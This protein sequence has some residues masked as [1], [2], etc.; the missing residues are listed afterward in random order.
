VPTT[1]QATAVVVVDPA[2][3]DDERFALAGFL[4][5]AAA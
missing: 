1:T 4:A 3:S 2:F 5:V